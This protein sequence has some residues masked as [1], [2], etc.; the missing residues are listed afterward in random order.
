MQISRFIRQGLSLPRQK[1]EGSRR[2]R[3]TKQNKSETEFN[4]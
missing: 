3:I 4:I 1:I 2:G